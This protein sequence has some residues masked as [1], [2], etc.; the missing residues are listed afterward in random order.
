M[1]FL[2]DEASRLELGLESSSAAFPKLLDLPLSSFHLIQITLSL[3]LY[4]YAAS[5]SISK[6]FTTNS[7]QSYMWRLQYKACL[8]ANTGVVLNFLRQLI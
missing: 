5:F 4:P 3:F 6:E 1:E 8:K 7:L 2:R